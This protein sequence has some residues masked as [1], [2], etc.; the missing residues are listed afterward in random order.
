MKK[1]LNLFLVASVII[2]LGSCSKNAPNQGGQ[3]ALPSQTPTTTTT[4]TTTEPEPTKVTPL[5]LVAPNEEIPSTFT[6]K[7]VLEENTGEWCGWCPEGAKIMEDAIAANPGKVIGIAVHDGD[8]MT[9]A[10]YNSWHKTYTGVTGFPNGN[11]S[12]RK[13]ASRG[14]WMASITNDLAANNGKNDAGIALI[15][16]LEGSMLNITAFIGYAKTFS[17]D[18]RLSIV[19]T[20]DKVPLSAPGA[21]SNYSSSVT[22]TDAWLHG[23]VFRAVVTDKEG[24]KIDMTN[25]STKYIV[26]EFKDID[27]SKMKIGNMSNVHVAAYINAASGSTNPGADN[28]G[29]WI[30]NAQDVK[31]GEIQKFD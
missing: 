26:K 20:E 2:G 21:Q 15:T 22:V 16:K 27:L 11:V 19:I 30:I 12:R 24:D 9:V 31:A 7:V 5:S 4:T 25:S 17:E 28:A 23:H 29:K 8:P 10:D 3:F 14:S 18:T 13:A 6:Q 1:V